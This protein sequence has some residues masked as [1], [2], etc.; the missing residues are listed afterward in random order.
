MR[1]LLRPKHNNHEKQTLLIIDTNFAKY[2][3]KIMVFYK[4]Q[5]YY[6]I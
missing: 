3:S 6:C 5:Y 2:A 1:K 4:T